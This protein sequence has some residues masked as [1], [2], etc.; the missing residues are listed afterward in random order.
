MIDGIYRFLRLEEIIG[1]SRT[2]ERLLTPKFQDI[3]A[4]IFHKYAVRAQKKSVKNELTIPMQRRY[5]VGI[6]LGQV[7][8]HVSFSK[9]FLRLI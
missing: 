1:T 2:W 9:N 5:G 4:K 8:R 3:F 6:D 7:E